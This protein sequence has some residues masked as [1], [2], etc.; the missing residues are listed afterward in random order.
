MS[1][2]RCCAGRPSSLAGRHSGFWLEAKKHPNSCTEIWACAREKGA[3]PACLLI[4]VRRIPVGFIKCHPSGVALGDHQ[5]WLDAIVDFGWKQKNI[6]TPAQKY[7]HVRVK[8]VRCQRA[9]SSR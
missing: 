7:G 2:I 8:R 3:M 1:S 5:V 4:K 9:Y 6:P